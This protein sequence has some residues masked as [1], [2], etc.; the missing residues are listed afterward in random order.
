MLTALKRDRI[1]LFL[2]PRRGLFEAAKFL[3]PA[4]VEASKPRTHLVIGHVHRES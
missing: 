3:I 2:L 1:S 4:S